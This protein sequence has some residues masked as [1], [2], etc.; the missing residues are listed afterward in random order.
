MF[1]EQPDFST[2]KGVFGNSRNYINTV[3]T[4]LRA[5]PVMLRKISDLKKV[6]II[7]NSDSHSTNFNRIGREATVF[8]KNDLNYPNIIDSLR[9]N[10]IIKTY[11]FKTSAGKYY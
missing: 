1:G 10:K 4:G 11:E 7:S 3:E 5:D 8:S 2:L 6:S 9:R